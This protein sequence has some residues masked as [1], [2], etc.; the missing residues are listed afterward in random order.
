MPSSASFSRASISSAACKGDPKMWPRQIFK[1]PS[2][3]DGQGH[4]RAAHIPGKRSNSDIGTPIVGGQW[5]YD[6]TINGSE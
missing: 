6:H 2:K 4:I 5:P 1:V 3:R